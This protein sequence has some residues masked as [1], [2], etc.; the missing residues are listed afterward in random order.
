[1][2]KNIDSF[3]HVLKQSTD[4]AFL[5]EGNSNKILSVSDVVSTILG[6][7]KEELISRNFS[8]LFPS[9][10]LSKKKDLLERIKAFGGVFKNQSFLNAHGNIIMM[11]LSAYPI[12]DDS[13]GNQMIVLLRDRMEILKYEKQLRHK[14]NLEKLINKL[15]VDFI[16]CSAKEISITLNK[17]LERLCLFAEANRAYIFLIDSDNKTISNTHEWCTDGISSQRSS[18]Q[19]LSI[20]FFPWLMERLRA[21]KSISIPDVAKM[22]AEAHLEK[23][24][25]KEQDILSLDIFPLSI[26]NNLMGF[27]GFDYVQSHTNL[28]EDSILLL[29]TMGFLFANAIAR[30]NDMKELD[31]KE[32]DLQETQTIAKIGSWK[33][34]VKNNDFW[35]SQEMKNI[36]GLD[37]KTNITNLS[38]LIKECVYPADKQ[39]T[40]DAIDK[41]KK[42]GNIYDF[43]FRIIPLASNDIRWLR[44][45][46]IRKKKD[47]PYTYCGIIQDITER[48][49]IEE[50]MARASKLESL[51]TLAGGIAHNF[52]NILTTLLGNISFA[53]ELLDKNNPARNRLVFAQEAGQRAKKLV[54]HILTFSKGGI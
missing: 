22:P 45:T 53:E 51:G 33:W 5:L 41:L 19:K 6:Y 49:Q 36:H 30:K 2:Q 31:E 3:N 1:M 26:N 37:K 38:S 21:N 35:M 48:R 44:I 23:E 10:K 14:L 54:N 7:K 16:R 34:N 28:K 17:T 25:L 27:F 46:N 8:T 18:L 15:S 12:E 9:E 4:I 47:E 50:Q 52:N 39:I 42:D 13:N 40:I 20:D 29:K 11:D 32:K 43:S 24:I